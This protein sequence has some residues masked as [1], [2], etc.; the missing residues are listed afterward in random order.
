MPVHCSASGKLLLALLPSRERKRIVDALP[1]LRFTINT[2]TERRALVAAMR[3]IRKDNVST[4]N[5]EYL[6]GTV[7]VAGPVENKERR[8]PAALAVHAPSTRMTMAE[9]LRHVPA[10]RRAAAR[11]ADTFA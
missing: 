1:L 10:L 8:I 3:R 2:I 9:A 7:C 4:D 6:T 5:E 11:L